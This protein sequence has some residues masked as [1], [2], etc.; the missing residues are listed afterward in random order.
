[1]SAVSSLASKGLELMKYPGIEQAI[2]KNDSWAAQMKSNRRGINLVILTP[3][4]PQRK[5]FL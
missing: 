3:G 5:K 2:A 1:M 4:F